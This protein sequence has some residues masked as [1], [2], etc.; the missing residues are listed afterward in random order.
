MEIS[1]FKNYLC[2]A[3]LI[4]FTVTISGPLAYS[5]SKNGKWVIGK[6]KNPLDD[7]E[8][9]VAIID[10]DNGTGGVFTK[11][12]ITLVVR[13]QSNKT[14]IYVNWHEYL[15]NDASYL[16]GQT[17][18]KVIYR[19][20]PATARTD[21]WFVSTDNEATFAPDSIVFP[22]LRAM[23]KG[24]RFVAQTTPYGEN[25]ITAIFDMTGSSKAIAQIAKT[26]GWTL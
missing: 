1:M 17:K 16:D 11:K 2:I 20:P 5:N 7:S 24:N 4:I 21:M 12:A 25:P 18:K 13:C 8:T 22:L 19:V 26:C 3:I 6:S 10:A 23:A 14:D 15:G 9:V